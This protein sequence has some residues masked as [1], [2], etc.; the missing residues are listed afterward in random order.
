M[1]GTG[2]NPETEAKPTRCDRCGY[3]L[4]FVHDLTEAELMFAIHFL[5]EIYAGE[6]E[7]TRSSHPPE[8]VDLMLR[9]DPH[10]V[11]CQTAIRRARRLLLAFPDLVSRPVV[12]GDLS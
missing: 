11:L 9:D 10:Y 2:Q 5:T 4:P 6:G 1:N 8:P 3:G 7:P 12:G